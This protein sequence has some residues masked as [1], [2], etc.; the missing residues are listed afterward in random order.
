MRSQRRNAQNRSPTG[1]AA[2]AP[3]SFSVYQFARRH[4]LS[5]P[6]VY[7]EIHR[8]DLPAMRVGKGGSLRVTTAH[9]A[10]WMQRRA[11]SVKP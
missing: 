9:E 5:A 6:T 8:G 3:I 1:P 11:F 10:Q 4:G 7:S 2:E